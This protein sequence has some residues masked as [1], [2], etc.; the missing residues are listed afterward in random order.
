MAKHYKKLDSLTYPLNPDAAYFCPFSPF[1]D[2]LLVGLYTLEN[3]ETQ[4][5]IGGVSLFDTHH[6]KLTEVASL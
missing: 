5:V 4:K 6:S 3:T 2:L 1:Y